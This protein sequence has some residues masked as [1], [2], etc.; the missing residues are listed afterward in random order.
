MSSVSDA[1]GGEKMRVVEVN[2]MREVGHSGKSNDGDH[3]SVCGLTTNRD[4]NSSQARLGGNR[5]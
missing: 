2:E 1:G 4:S 5:C 3:E